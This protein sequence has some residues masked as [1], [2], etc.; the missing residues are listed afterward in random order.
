MIGAPVL[1]YNVIF[2][3]LA[4][5]SPFNA[6]LRPSSSSHGA[7]WNGVLYKKTNADYLI[8]VFRFHDFAVRKLCGLPYQNTVS[9]L[10]LETSGLL[11]QDSSQSWGVKS[12]GLEPCINC[13]LSFQ[14][15]HTTAKKNTRLS[16]VMRSWTWKIVLGLVL[17]Q[18]QKA[19]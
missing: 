3:V 18:D 12:K 2:V 16:K 1:Q 14:M 17:V 4:F 7:Q 11:V 9:R 13:T 10:G 8:H 5:W 6:W 19:E 15:K